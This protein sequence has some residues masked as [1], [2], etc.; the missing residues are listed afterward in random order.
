MDLRTRAAPKRRLPE[1][2]IDDIGEGEDS[3]RD[4]DGS[5]GGAWEP[6]PAGSAADLAE[7]AVPSGDG[8]RN[9]TSSVSDGSADAIVVSPPSQ[10]IDVSSWDALEDY[11]ANYQART[12]QIFRVRTNTTATERNT[13]I[14]KTQSSAEKIPAVWDQYA[15]TFV[16]THYGNFKSQG[17]S[18]WPRQESRRQGCRAQETIQTVAGLRKAGTKKTSILKI[19]TDNSGSN[20]Q[21]QDVHNL[22]AKLKA[23][24]NENGPSTS[25]KRL[26]NWMAEFGVQTGNVGRSFVDDVNQKKIAT[27]ITLQTKHMRAIFEQFREVLLI[28]ATHGTNRSKYK[29]FS[30]MAHDTFGKSQFVQHALLQNER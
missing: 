16:C 23:S 17:N 21:P 24:E 18:E 8:S 20:S 7:Q 13:K 15:K 10:Q 22:V 14:D 19:I 3:S 12:F 4:S 2:A 27:C 30:L 1:E 11:L 29:V 28:D 5:V 6:S 25:G 26:K 9:A